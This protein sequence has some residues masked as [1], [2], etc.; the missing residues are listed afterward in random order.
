[1][2]DACS[3]GRAQSEGVSEGRKR[4]EIEQ[5]IRHT[6]IDTRDTTTVKLVSTEM[7]QTTYAGKYTTS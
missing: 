7:K 4:Q 2:K 1:M 5:R 6:R 3:A